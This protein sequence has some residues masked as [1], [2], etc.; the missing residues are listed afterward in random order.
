MESGINLVLISQSMRGGVVEAGG[1]GDEGGAAPHGCIEIAATATTATMIIITSSA[2][3]SP[4]RV[5]T[6]LS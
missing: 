4:A 6:A 5:H 1:I 2:V 3:A